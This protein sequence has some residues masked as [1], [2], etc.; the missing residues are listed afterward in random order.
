MTRTALSLVLAALLVAS[1]A[2]PAAAH[3]T[4]NPS[5]ASSLYFKTDF[6][7]PHGCDG[8]AT[9]AVRVQIPEGVTNAKPQVVAGWEIEVI[10]TELDEPVEGGHGETI[11]DRVSEIAWRGGPLPD[12]HLQEFGLSMRLPDAADVEGG[13]L[14]FPVVQECEDGEHRWIEIPDTVEQWGDLDEPAPYVRLASTGGGDG[15]GHGDDEGDDVEGRDEDAEAHGDEGDTADATATAEDD[16]LDL[17]AATTGDAGPITW[18]ALVAGLLG[19]A[20]GAGAFVR[21][22][23][24]TEA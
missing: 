4:A 23:R 5:E 2:L 6:R 3:V 14:W 15:H 21:A 13:V 19:L 17:A 11:T 1:F 8:S 20:L 24:R 7:I 9:T 22:G 16:D 12:A 18:A 10:R